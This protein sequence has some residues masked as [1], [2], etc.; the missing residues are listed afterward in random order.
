MKIADELLVLKEGKLQAKGSYTDLVSGPILDSSDRSVVFPALV[1]ECTDQ[2][3]ELRFGPHII[4][5]SKTVASAGEKVRVR[6]KASDVSLFRKKPEQTSLLNIFKGKVTGIETTEDKENYITLDLGEQ[7][8]LSKI[9]ALST[10]NL[11]VQP[12]Q[13]LWLA[14]KSTAVLS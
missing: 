8:V 2:G 4:R 5:C 6:I 3:S 11:G 10:Q 7:K 12:D 9:S 1:Q 14:V 13:E